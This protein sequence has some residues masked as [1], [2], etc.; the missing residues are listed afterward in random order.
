MPYR[1]ESQTISHVVTGL[2][3]LGLS[4]VG[5][6][7]WLAWTRVTI[8]DSLTAVAVGSMTALATLLTTFTPSPVPGGRRAVDVPVVPVTTAAGSSTTV[9]PVP[10]VGGGTQASGGGQHD[11]T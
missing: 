9:A 3:A 5:L 4:S 1:Y 8:P 6:I 11:G 2:V 7:G 10:T